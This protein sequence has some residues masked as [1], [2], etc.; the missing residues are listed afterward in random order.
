MNCGT[1]PNRHAHEGSPSSWIVVLVIFRGKPCP[2][3]LAGGC[4]KCWKWN[5]ATV[6]ERYRTSRHPTAAPSASPFSID[7]RQ[8]REDSTCPVRWQ[9]WHPPGVIH[10]PGPPRDGSI[11]LR[12]GA[13]GALPNRSAHPPAN[14][15][16]NRGVFPKSSSTGDTVSKTS[17]AVPRIA[18]RERG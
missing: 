4:S 14:T 11:L 12:L 18:A 10:H 16:P 13:N 15:R 7:L 6:G 2:L 5:M 9:P 1:W 8:R 3:V 17:D